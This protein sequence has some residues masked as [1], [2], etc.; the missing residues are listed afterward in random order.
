VTDNRS[1]FVGQGDWPTD[2]RTARGSRRDHGQ[3][4][5]DTLDHPRCGVESRYP[6]ARELGRELGVEVEFLT[7]ELHAR[8]STDW[9]M[10]PQS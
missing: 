2:G 3:E 10:H 9:Q 4:I 5:G 8:R 1:D 6:L 7:R